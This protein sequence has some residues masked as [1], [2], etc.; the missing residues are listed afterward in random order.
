MC[1]ISLKRHCSIK[2]QGFAEWLEKC[3]PIMCCL[4]KSNFKYKDLSRL[5][6]QRWKKYDAVFLCLCIF[7]TK[8]MIGKIEKSSYI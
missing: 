7:K 4:Q 8:K 2:R 5:K 1:Y 6:V 3:D